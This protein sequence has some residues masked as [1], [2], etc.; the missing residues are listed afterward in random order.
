MVPLVDTKC[1]ATYPHGSHTGAPC[2]FWVVVLQ[3]RF[4]ETFVLGTHVALDLYQV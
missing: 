3:A 4:L 2:L 1:C